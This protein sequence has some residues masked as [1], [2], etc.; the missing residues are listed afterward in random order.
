LSEV[1]VSFDAVDALAG[2]S[3]TVGDGQS[4]GLI[5][6]NGAGKT[7][8]FN[9]ISGYVR[10]RQ[11]R[12]RY[13]GQRVTDWSPQ[14]RARAGIARTFQNVGLDKHATVRDNLLLAT[15]PSDI[16]STLRSVVGRRQAAA[17][18]APCRDLV[19]RLGLAPSVDEVVGVLPAGIAKLVE[20]VCA[21]ATNPRLLLLDEPS[22]GL[23]P[24][25]RARLTD[26]LNVIRAT[27]GISVLMIEHDMQL[28]M[29][30]SDYLYVLNFGALLAHGTPQEIREDERVIEAYLGKAS[31]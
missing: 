4:V 28:A 1:T 11:G 15:E 29:R 5:G 27:S 19:D 7:T 22:S 25:E 31:R 24:G 23:G 2:V 6:P 9:V 18:P 10:P 20:L 21:T 17:I 16:G 30:L 14:M 13:C 12:V 26:A 3:L 8:L